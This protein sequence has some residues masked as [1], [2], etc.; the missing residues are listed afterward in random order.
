MEIH[1][2]NVASVIRL[3]DAYGAKNHHQNT[4]EE[5]DYMHYDFKAFKANKVETLTFVLL[6]IYCQY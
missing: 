1:Q 4:L 2:I 6:S 3:S 5:L